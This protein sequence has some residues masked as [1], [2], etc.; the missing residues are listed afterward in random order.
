M[1][2]TTIPQRRY[3]ARRMA[4]RE[5]DYF[6]DTRSMES[7]DLRTSNIIRAGNASPRRQGSDGSD[8]T[9]YDG[10]DT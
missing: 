1:P 10:S 8:E 4:Q 2:Y 9:L 5:D 3:A 6:A 7:L